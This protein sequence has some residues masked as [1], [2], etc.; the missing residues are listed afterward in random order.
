MIGRHSNTQQSDDAFESRMVQRLRD[1]ADTLDAATRSRLNRARQAAL[2]ELSP[3]PAWKRGPAL[4]GAMIAAVAVIAVLM[5][6]PGTDLPEP[7]AGLDAPDL[8]LLMADE[9]LEMLEDLEF[10]TWLAA[11]ELEGGA[12]G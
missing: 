5:W 4:A 9:N 7:P 1:S 10:Y 6:R 3:H 12:A 2:N 8:E 11:T